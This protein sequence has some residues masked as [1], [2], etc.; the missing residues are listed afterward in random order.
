M[1]SNDSGVG[2]LLWLE[3]EMWEYPPM[4]ASVIWSVRARTC[5]V[6]ELSDSTEV[7]TSIPK[8]CYN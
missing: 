5:T 6:K 3:E 4:H 7:R 2:A 8:L 1:T